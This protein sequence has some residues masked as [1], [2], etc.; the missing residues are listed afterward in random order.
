MELNAAGLSAVQAFRETAK[1]KF[2]ANQAMQQDVLQADVEL[3][4]LEQRRIEIDQARHVAIARINTLLHREPQLWLPPPPQ[5]FEI[6]DELPEVGALREQA[7]EKRPDLAAQ[8]ARINAE[9]N[10]LALA[11][12]EF[13]PDFELMGRYDTFWT[14]PAQRGQVGMNMNVP[15]NQN[16]R[17]AAVREA[18]F[19][20]NKMEAEYD[21]QVDMVRNE[22]QTAFARL[23]ASRRSLDLFSE[24]LLPATNDNVAAANSGYTAGTLD[25]LRLIQAQREFIDLNEKHQQAIVEYYRNRAELDRVVGA[26]L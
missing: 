6:S 17:N 14:D 5:R 11:C 12:K 15:L 23:Q 21:Q 18:M 4:R 1:S 20:V 10:E 7:I 13:Y 16:R 8:A 24:K 2:E 9:K 19:R 25:F 3:A 26:G 22:V